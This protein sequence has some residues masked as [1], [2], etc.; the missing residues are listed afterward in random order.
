MILTLNNV[1]TAIKSVYR[2]KAIVGQL[3]F[4]QAV[5]ESNLDGKPSRLAVEFK[6]LFG[7][8]DTD[9]VNKRDLMTTEC[10]KTKCWKESQPFEFFN[11][12][13]DCIKWHRKLM[14]RSRYSKVWNAKTFEEAC[15][16]VWRAGYAT[17]PNYPSKLIKRYYQNDGL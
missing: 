12:Y 5:L 13:E 9:G 11:S 16:E 3:C 17:D 10:N 7:I 2:D 15:T 6:N 8:K 14:Q 4:A 1:R